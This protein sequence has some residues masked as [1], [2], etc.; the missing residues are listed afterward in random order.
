MP[1]ELGAACQRQPSLASCC[2]FHSARAPVLPLVTCC[3]LAQVLYLDIAQ[4]NN[5]RSPEGRCLLLDFHLAQLDLHDAEHDGFGQVLFKSL[6]RL[7]GGLATLSGERCWSSWVG[8]V[9]HTN[10]IMHRAIKLTP[11]CNTDGVVQA[12]IEGV[13]VHP[14]S[15]EPPPC[16]LAH[17]AYDREICPDPCV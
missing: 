4:S 10:V 17:A 5:V 15:A 16:H 1:K 6:S 9:E 7:R 3:L 11:S 8:R 14:L 13:S 12:S 2:R